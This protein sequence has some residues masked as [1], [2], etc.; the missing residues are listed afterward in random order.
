MTSRKLSIATRRSQ[1]SRA[2]P[3]L[4]DCLGIGNVVS[5]GCF[6]VERGVLGVICLAELLKVAGVS[7]LWICLLIVALG[8]TESLYFCVM[9]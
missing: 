7:W 3:M 9:L 8:G 1:R 2:D 4:K 5:D 6:A